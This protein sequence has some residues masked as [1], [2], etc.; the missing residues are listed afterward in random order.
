M[1]EK[2]NP[3]E[4]RV[5]VI[6]LTACGAM[7]LYFLGIEPLSRDWA[8]VHRRLT[9]AREKVSLL[10]LD[11]KS[12]QTQRQKKLL[13]IVPVLEMPRPSDQQGPLFQEAFTNQLK[14]VGLMSKRMQLTRGRALRLDTAAPVVLNVA[15][16]GSGTYEQIL[17]LLADLPHNPYCG[18]VQKLSIK[19]DAKERQNL[20]WEITVFS[21]ASQ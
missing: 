19:P 7:L 13:E 11:P 16:Q 18:G 12:A 21:Y 14:K 1:L 5:L 2:L 17:N 6:C 4:K 20:D 15:S 8:D 9:E 3:R 10:K